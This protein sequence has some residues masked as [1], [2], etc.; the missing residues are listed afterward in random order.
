MSR[1]FLRV[2]QGTDKYISPW[3]ISNI[4][5]NLASEYYKKYVLDQ[6]SDKVLNIN[7]HQ[8][9]II[10]NSSFD[11]YQR[12]SK[13]RDFNVLDREDIESLYYLGDIIPMSPSIKITKL[14]LIFKVHRSIY[15]LLKKNDILMDRSKM[16]EYIDPNFNATP[17]INFDALKRYVDSLISEGNDRLKNKCETVMKNAEESLKEFV[18]DSVNLG[19]IDSLDE[20]ELDEYIKDPKNRNF[21]QRYYGEFYKTYRRYTR[22]IVAI[23]DIESGDIDI[24]AKEFIKEDLQQGNEHKIEV[25]ELS[26]NSP[27]IISWVV[28]YIAS[29]FIANVFINALD[30]KRTDIEEET[31]VEG[32][33]L[34]NPEVLRL[35]EA[36]R[37]LQTVTVADE[38]NDKVIRIEDFKAKRGLGSVNESI[39]RNVE[40]TFEKNEFLNS[41]IEITPVLEDENEDE[42]Q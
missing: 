33:E 11:L 14:G 13:L 20:Q 37:Q 29:S 15:K 28:G 3:K 35:R 22:P 21:Y 2:K 38:F 40:D 4:I 7:E 24:L 19:I 25:K 23:L 17:D 8:I 42:D 41:N 6:L 12:Y 39:K 18:E 9:P 26:K 16:L 10:F 32:D 1:Y 31:S 36:M 30:N 34:V 5:E 27:T